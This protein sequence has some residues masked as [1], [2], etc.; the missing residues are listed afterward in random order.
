MR[1]TASSS[2]RSPRV[3]T[4]VTPAF[5]ARYSR[6]AATRCSRCALAWLAKL[7]EQIWDV[8]SP[9]SASERPQQGLQGRS[10]LLRLAELSGR[11]FSLLSEFV[12]FPTVSI[13]E[14]REDCRQGALFLK[15]ALNRL[16]ANAVILPG[17]PGRNPLVL[18]T[19]SPVTS[20]SPSRRRCLFYGHY[21][22]AELAC[23]VVELAASSSRVGL[24]TGRAA[25]GR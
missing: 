11:L 3:R 12:A 9:E 17:E 13:D 1:T 25:R 2:P 22:C 5:A 10:A 6:E 21:E 24:Q 15:R 8:S 7:T 20:P 14:H 23:G 18:A 19:F 4:P 16:G